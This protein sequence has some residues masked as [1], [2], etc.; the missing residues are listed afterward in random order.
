MKNTQLNSIKTIV[1]EGNKFVDNQ[2]IF[3]NIC[4]K[5]GL[6]ISD[7]A[8]ELMKKYVDHLMDWN[9]KVNL[10]SRKDIANIWTR[11]ILGSIS[12]L[13]R[14]TFYK[15]ASVVDIGTGGG[16]PGIPIAVIRDD[17]HMLLVDSIQKKMVALH[18]IL[19]DLKLPR[20]SAA[21]GRAEELGTSTK[22]CGKFDYVVA[23]AVAPIADLIKWGKPFLKKNDLVSPRIDEEGEIPPGSIIMLKGGDLSAEIQSAKVTCKPRLLDRRSINIEGFYGDQDLID[24]KLVIVQP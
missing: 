17:L 18:A 23:R 7:P 24:K 6:N 11:H 3:R 15:G 1:Y 14:N 19:D 20:V 10:I 4:R 2:L 13:F 16:L 9:T 21:A 22:Y 8:L 12:F 5:N